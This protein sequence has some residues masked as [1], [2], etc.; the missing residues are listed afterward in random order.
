MLLGSA[1]II[2]KRANKLASC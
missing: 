2:T 1:Y